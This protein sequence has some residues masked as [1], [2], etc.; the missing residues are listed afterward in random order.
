MTAI[1][2]PWHKCKVF[3]TSSRG[4]SGDPPRRDINSL[5]STRSLNGNLLA[6]CRRVT[7]SF[8][9]GYDAQGRRPQSQFFWLIAEGLQPLQIIRRRSSARR[10]WRQK[11]TPSKYPSTRQ[12]TT[13]V[14]GCQPPLV[15]R[16]RIV[17]RRSRRQD[18]LLKLS[19]GA[20]AHDACGGTTTS[21]NHPSAQQRTRF[22]A[23]DVLH[24]STQ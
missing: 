9:F 4:L 22:E 15:I 21:Q 1:A 5:A 6:P 12:R 10:L 7:T 23:R 2:A 19:I 20:T 13:F 11:T 16:R 24:S 14:E 3:T 18:N 17:A 8:V